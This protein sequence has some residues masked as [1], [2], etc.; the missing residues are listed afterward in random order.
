MQLDYSLTTPEERTELVKQILSLI[1]NPSPQYLEKAADYILFVDKRDK[2][3]KTVT[4]GRNVTIKKREISFEGLSSSLESGEDGLHSLIRNDKNILF[5]PKIGI[6]AEDL[7]TIPHLKE[8]YETREQLK[9]QLVSARGS[10]AYALKKQIIELSQDQ[11]VVKMHYKPPVHSAPQFNIPNSLS[12]PDELSIAEDGLPRN[13]G[14]I[15]FFNPAHISFLLSNYSKLSQESWEEL[16]GDLKWTLLDLE[17]LV[18]KSL[19]PLQLDI[20][21]LKIDGAENAKISEY[22]FKKY[23]KQLSEQRIST[24]WRSKIP[25]SIAAA[26]TKQYLEW[27]YTEVEYGKWKR[28][29]RCKQIKLAHPIFFSRN[30]SSKSGFYSI[31]KECRS[32]RKQ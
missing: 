8:I 30:N 17:A 28:C 9:S 21:T 24:I 5:C 6:S 3:K 20:L 10:R 23:N 29:G 18:D 15:S 27:Y 12:L 19:T 25:K 13:D 26:A 1:S 2:T 7:E 22:I 11:Y 31:C 14:V 16:Q 4:H 32:C